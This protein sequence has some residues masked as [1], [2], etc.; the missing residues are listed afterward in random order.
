MPRALRLCAVGLVLCSGFLVACDYTSSADDADTLLAD[1]RLARQAGDLDKAVALLEQALALEPG[2]AGVRVELASVYLQRAEIDLLD[3]DRMMLFLAEPAPP[4]VP[5]PG[6]SGLG[7][8]PGGGGTFCPL[9]YDP[10]ATPFA[11]SDAEGYAALLGE[12]AAVETALALLHDVPPGG[13]PVMPEALRALELCT[14][15]VDGELTYDRAEALAA[16]RATGLPDVEIASAL[17]VNGAT[18]FLDSYFFLA[19]ELTQPATWYR[20]EGLGLGACVED[21]L[22]LREETTGALAD[23]FEALT[24]LDLRAELLGGT[25]AREIVDHG[26]V[27]YEAIRLYLGPVCGS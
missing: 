10:R 6:G 21:P 2:H 9:E 15:V 8:G 3:I 24:S 14:A 11:L 13:G 25:A 27:V 26:L 1:A 23:F 19:E 7:N 17:A 22:A 12:E 4:P 16:L 5:P 18:R 20:I